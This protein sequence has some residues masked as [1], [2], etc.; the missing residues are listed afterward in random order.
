MNILKSVRVWV[1][2][3]AVV[4]SLLMV[5]NIIPMNKGEEITFGNGLDYG[6]DFAGGIQMQLKLDRPLDDA[7]TMAVEKGILENRLNAMG[8]KDIVIRPWGNQYILLEI[9]S[10]SPS[11]I[12]RI[13][14]I[15]K[16]QARFEARIDGELAISG[17]DISIDLSPEGRG[18]SRS[19]PSE[20]YVAI[21]NS[22]AGG[23]SFCR[24]GKDKRNK[25]IDMFLD[26][27][28]NTFFL[29]DNGTYSILK[30]LRGADLASYVKIIENR[31]L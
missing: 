16:Q 27:P 21:T 23:E 1:M 22:M 5:F 3:T 15:L 8:L 13:E 26:R 31:S 30:E 10:A 17:S 2:I 20:W 11:D 24:V 7:N 12:A 14:D 29:M 25:P 18:V 19:E 28:E 6:L 4:L 9:A